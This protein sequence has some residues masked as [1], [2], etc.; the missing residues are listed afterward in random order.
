MVPTY[1]K[2]SYNLV[3]VATKLRKGKSF[4]VDI[5]DMHVSVVGTDYIDAVARANLVA[6]AVKQYYDAN[7][8]KLELLTEYEEVALKAKNR[9]FA[10]YISIGE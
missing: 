1:F 7:G 9:S 8:I 2:P 5:P 4:Q 3:A 6:T 10:I